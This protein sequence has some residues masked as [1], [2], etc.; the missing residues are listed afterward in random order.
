MSESFRCPICKRVVAVKAE[1][2]RFRPFCSERC[3]T[4]DLGSWLE[5]RYQISNPTEDADDLPVQGPK[6]DKGEA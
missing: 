3:R 4:I 5:A 1:E 6:S 2:A